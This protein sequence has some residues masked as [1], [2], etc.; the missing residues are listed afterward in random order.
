[1][2]GVCSFLVRF[3]V[4]GVRT[5]EEVGVVAQGLSRRGRGFFGNTVLVE[6]LC[7]AMGGT[8]SFHGSRSRPRRAL[9]HTP[10]LETRTK[11]CYARASLWA[12]TPRAQGN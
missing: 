7:A 8:R 5:E 4:R 1:L 10:R 9:P 6:W 2:W 3:F 12:V 11:E